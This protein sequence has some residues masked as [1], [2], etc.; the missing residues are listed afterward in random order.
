MILKNVGKRASPAGYIKDYEGVPAAAMAEL[1]GIH[2]NYQLPQLQPQLFAWP[3]KLPVAMRVSSRAGYHHPLAY[4]KYD[5][6]VYHPMDLRD[7]NQI[8]ATNVDPRIMGRREEDQEADAQ[9]VSQHSSSG[10][11]RRSEM[12]DDVAAAAEYEDLQQQQRQETGL[13]I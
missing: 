1:E 10:A 3:P 6:D 4:P 8:D 7:L 9:T 5:D 2:N 11:G 13:N 12:E